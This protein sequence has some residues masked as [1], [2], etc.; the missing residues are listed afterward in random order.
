MN[1]G[2][3]S[4]GLG[5]PP[6]LRSEFESNWFYCLAGQ[7]STDM[8]VWLG[9]I[10]WISTQFRVFLPP[11]QSFQVEPDLAED[12]TPGK[13]EKKLYMCMQISFFL[14]KVQ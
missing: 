12:K 10:D 13:N 2:L 9:R 7:V 14:H 6:A 4:C 5:N 3:D 11:V 1:D 8:I